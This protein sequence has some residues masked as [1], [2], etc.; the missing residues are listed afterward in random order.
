MHRNYY[1]DYPC[2]N[3]LKL[4]K[5]FIHIFSL[6]LPACTV[7]YAYA[8]IVHSS[9]LGQLLLLVSVLHHY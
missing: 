1:Y 2:L 5:V 7:F 3:S 6:Y 8:T 4:Q 9:V